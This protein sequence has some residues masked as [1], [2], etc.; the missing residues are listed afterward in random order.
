MYSAY[1]VRMREGNDRPWVKLRPL[2]ANFS[3]VSTAKDMRT[4]RYCDSGCWLV[5]PHFRARQH[6]RMITNASL[7]ENADVLM[8]TKRRNL[9]IEEACRVCFIPH[10]RIF[11]PR[12][13]RA[14]EQACERLRRGKHN[15]PVPLYHPLIMAPEGRKRYHG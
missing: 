4:V 7:S 2:S 1:T 8:L 3:E 6:L 5:A 13:I 10:N 11:E 9:C 12:Q 15:R 14:H